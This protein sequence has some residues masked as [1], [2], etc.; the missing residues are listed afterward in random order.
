MAKIK[1][2]ALATQCLDRR[3]AE[4]GTLD[5]EALAWARNRNKARKTVHWK[6]TKHAAREKLKSKYP[7]LAN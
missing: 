1:S 3:I 4:Q 2:V 7:M 6:F 5:K